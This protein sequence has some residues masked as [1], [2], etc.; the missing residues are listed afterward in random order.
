[1][2][3]QVGRRAAGGF[4]LTGQLGERARHA[5]D[6]TADAASTAAWPRRAACSGEVSAVQGKRVHRTHHNKNRSIL[7]EGPELVI[8]PVGTRTLTRDDA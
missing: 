1:V 6:S 2:F 5:T 4:D 3:A 7:V 8:R